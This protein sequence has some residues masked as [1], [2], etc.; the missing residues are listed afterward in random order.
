MIT[1]LLL[2]ANQRSASAQPQKVSPNTTLDELV[3]IEVD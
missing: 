2:I 3:D 1:L